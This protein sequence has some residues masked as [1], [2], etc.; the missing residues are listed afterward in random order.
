M[1]RNTIVKI[2][3]ALV[4]IFIAY[5]IL[6]GYRNEQ[7]NP[8]DSREN[9]FVT[10]PPLKESKDAMTPALPG[11]KNDPLPQGIAT[12]PLAKGLSSE[13]L[14]HGDPEN[15]DFSEFAPKNA[16]SEQNFLDSARLVGSDTAL[17]KNSNYSLRKDPEIPQS[18]KDSIPWGLSTYQNDPLRKPLDC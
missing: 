4:I 14:P 15:T 12:N 10:L 6:Q 5:K 7:F 1:K 13:L 11:T 18:G 2:A 3:L 16:L 8:Y 9:M 17:K